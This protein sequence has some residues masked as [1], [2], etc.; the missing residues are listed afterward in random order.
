LADRLDRTCENCGKSLRN[1]N[2]NAKT[3]SDACRMVIYRKNKAS[4]DI[5]TSET[6][7]R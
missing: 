5:L 4:K 2:R 3:C 6:N 1:K 7:R